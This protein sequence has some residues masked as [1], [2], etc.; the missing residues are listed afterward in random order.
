MIG[1]SRVAELD[2]PG[3]AVEGVS[4]RPAQSYWNESWERIR[5]NRIGLAAGVL[6][7]VFALIAIAAPLFSALLTHFLPQT[8]DLDVTFHPPGKPNWLG[9]DE[10][11]RDTLTRLIR[12]GRVTLGAAFLAVAISPPVGTSVVL[13][14][15]VS[16]KRV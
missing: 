16:G 2:M 1:Q 10:L 4:S 7:L 9:T 5:A 11:G 8:I 12:G 14:S 3:A 6:I 13:V 15:G